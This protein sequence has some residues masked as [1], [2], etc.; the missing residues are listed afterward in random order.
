MLRTNRHRTMRQLLALLPCLLI[1]SLFSGAASGGESLPAAYRLVKLG[2]GGLTG[3]SAFNGN[4][5]IAVSFE[6]D[7]GLSRAF[8]Y[9]GQSVTDIGTLGGTHAYVSG[10]NEKGEVAGHAYIV[11]NARFHAFIWSTRVGMRDLGSVGGT[12]ASTAGSATPINNR[13]Q[14]VGEST[15]PGALPQAFIWSEGGG[16]VSLGGLPGNPAGFSIAHMIN[17][18]GLVAG[19]GTAADGSTHAFIWMRRGGMTELGT[20]GGSISV[21]AGLSNSGMVAGNS[22]TASGLNH[23]FVWTRNGGMHDLGTAGG[24]E[25]YTAEKPMSTTGNVAGSIRF[26]DGTSH[27]AVWTRARGLRDLGTFGGPGSFAGGVNK[28]A[29]VVGAADITSAEGTAF[30]WTAQ[31]GKVDLNQR[32]C[33]PAPGLSLGAGLAISD[34][35]V[36]FASSNMGYVLLKPGCE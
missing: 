36:I 1:L 6:N 30:I 33:E 14:V 5:Q 12:G 21:A 22:T 13:S 2:S 11:G 9:D 16:M 27:A 29:Q 18:S 20:L 7:E 8:F 32:L 24:V 26:A 10:L 31:A 35:G 4:D 19:H 34:N 28:H 3:Y 17:E 25:S 23:M 15:A